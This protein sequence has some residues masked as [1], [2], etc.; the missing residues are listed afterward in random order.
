M[1]IHEEP[2]PQI[3]SLAFPSKEVAEVLTAWFKAK[4][5]NLPWRPQ[6]LSEYRDPYMVWI[7]ETMLQQTRVEAVIAHFL[8]W[9]RELPT[10]EALANS[11]EATVL[12]LWQGLGYYS[13]ARNLHKGACYILT[14]F[15]GR[16][17]NDPLLLQQIP[18]IGEYTAGAIASLAYHEHAPILDGNLVRIFSRWNLWSH[19]PTDS[20]EW[21]QKYWKLSQQFTDE[22]HPHLINEA[23]MDFGAIICTPKSPQCTDCIA[24]K[25]CKAFQAGKTSL[26]PPKK[27]KRESIDVRGVIAIICCAGKVLVTKSSKGFLKNQWRL[28]YADDTS[29]LQ[30]ILSPIH[31]KRF[32][33]P[34]IIKHTIT[35]HKI[36]FQVIT[37]T[38]DSLVLPHADEWKWIPVKELRKNIANALTIKALT[39]NQKHF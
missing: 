12:R 8:G 34:G 3:M 5:R 20:K 35:H 37:A 11:D 30:P 22:K 17:P 13:R 9:M 29:A 7:S 21:K 36:E 32:K 27:V 26:F 23:L 16:F 24:Q 19:L 14:E 10:V 18:G 31:I 2:C 6:R 4:H 28:P 33:S 38:I 1:G 15:G 25:F 39:L